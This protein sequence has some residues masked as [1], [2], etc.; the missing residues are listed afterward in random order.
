MLSYSHLDSLIETRRLTE[1]LN[2]SF[3]RI[4]EVGMSPEASEN[5]HIPGA[6]FWSIFSDLMKS[7]MSMN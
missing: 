5:A 6:V 2:D 1:Y 3:A 4:V 7:D